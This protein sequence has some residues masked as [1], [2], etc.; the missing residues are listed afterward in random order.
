LAADHIA[1]RA[2]GGLRIEFIGSLRVVDGIIETLAQ[3]NLPHLLLSDRQVGAPD[4]QKATRYRQSVRLHRADEIRESSE[5]ELEMDGDGV[6]QVER[7]LI[8]EGDK[9]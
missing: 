7:I 3:M 4:A 9:L 1:K 6:S 8:T 2:D 5:S